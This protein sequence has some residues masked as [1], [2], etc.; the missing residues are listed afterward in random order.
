MAKPCASLERPPGLCRSHR[1]GADR[2]KK[3][4]PACNQRTGKCNHI[5]V[6]NLS[7]KKR[8]IKNMNNTMKSLILTAAVSGLLGGTTA[9]LQAQASPAQP[10]SK[11]NA[12]QSVKA[13]TRLV[14]QSTDQDKT[15]HSCKGKNDCKGQ[16]GDGK[17]SCKG[18]G[19]CATDGS[20]PPAPNFA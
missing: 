8:M 9:R 15:K 14:A 7:K 11:T 19:S 10:N 2:N 6:V 16:G 18:K 5:T 13:G 1:P 17:N 12:T 20:K 3:S 4:F